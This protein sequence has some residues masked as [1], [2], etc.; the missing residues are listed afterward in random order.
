MAHDP[1]HLR[2]EAHRARWWALSVPDPIDRERIEAVRAGLRTYGW[3]RRTRSCEPGR[4]Q[5]LPQIDGLSAGR[6]AAERMF[7]RLPSRVIDDPPTAVFAWS[8]RVP[9]ARL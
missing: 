2:Q 5:P 1:D 6:C 7:R 3:H 9:R 4:L 8:R